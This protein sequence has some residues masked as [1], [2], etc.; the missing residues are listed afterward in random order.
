VLRIYDSDCT[1]FVL[2]LHIS[3]TVTVFVPV[4]SVTLCVTVIPVRIHKQLDIIQSGGVEVRRVRASTVAKRRNPS[5]PVLEKYVFTPYVEPSHL[6]L[7]TALRV[8]THIALENKPGIQ[9]NVVEVHKQGTTP[10]SPGLVPIF[11]DLPL[12]KAS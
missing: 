9:V 7:H 8:C 12:L 11:A 4:Y 1:D 3:H 5:K 6:D 2:L 10:L